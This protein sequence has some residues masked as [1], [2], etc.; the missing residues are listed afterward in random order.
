MNRRGISR[1]PP[2]SGPNRSER[3]MLTRRQDELFSH[4]ARLALRGAYAAKDGDK[5]SS[6]KPLI[7]SWT[8]I[9]SL[10][11]AV[12]Y[13]AR[14]VAWKIYTSAVNRRPVVENGRADNEQIRQFGQECVLL[15]KIGRGDDPMKY[16]LEF[17][18]YY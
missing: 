10:A 1:E 6:L 4:A 3:T 5:P 16:P 17:G 15:F 14:Q 18:D 2:V 13:Y 9:E 7:A 8:E 11:R 12:P